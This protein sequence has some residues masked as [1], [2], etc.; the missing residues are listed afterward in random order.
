M[1]PDQESAIESTDH[2]YSN[3][4]NPLNEPHSDD[5]FGRLLDILDA[6][7]VNVERA[8]LHGLLTS[9]A[10]M[11]APD[12]SRIHEAVSPGRAATVELDEAIGRVVSDIGEALWSLAF[13]ARS[14]QG[15]SADG[16]RWLRGYLYALDLHDAQW[17]VL[18]GESE[19]A[20]DAV[21]LCRT[22][23]GEVGGGPALPRHVDARV[24][25]A[26]PRFL[27]DMAAR[28]HG[29]VAG[30]PDW[31]RAE[32]TDA[33]GHRD[34]PA[35]EDAE[36]RAMDVEA[37]VRC[38]L[39]DG[40]RLPRRVVDE[41]IHR[42]DAM[43]TALHVVIDEWDEDDES[44]AW[45]SALHAV[46]IL[47]GVRGAAATEALLAGFLAV[48]ER[49]D[50][51]ADWL[52]TDWPRLF[53]NKE[54]RHIGVMRAIV[55]DRHAGWYA[56]SSAAECVVADA[57]E[58]A[59]ETLEAT[60][61]WILTLTRDTSDDVGFRRLAAMNLLELPRARH[62]RWLEA[63]AAEQVDA[64]SGDRLFVPAD[65]DAAFGEGDRPGWREAPDPLDFY[66]HE[67]IVERQARWAQEAVGGP[68]DDE[69][70]DDRGA[71]PGS[72][73]PYVRA[74]SKVG[75]NDPCPCGSGRKYK[76]CCMP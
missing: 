15:S 59:P 58:R 35:Y 12:L 75:R 14:A 18:L 61:D 24:L 42:G 50:D 52:G 3:P 73:G 34:L 11:P 1:L 36:L 64:P 2:V 65:V 74:Q 16:E 17:S 54:G 67:A 23:L 5:P 20:T 32:P 10:T 31:G 13:E 30:Q 76:R 39:D 45:W 56:R 21:A 37:L 19:V 53:L 70:F 8:W 46:K 60:L 27:A 49:A 71:G 44:D 26:S 51:M 62:R 43:V 47:G 68:F 33:G 28:M 38:V 4:T 55:E 63:M 22:L 25:L 69:S 57:F 72:D 29:A 9:T 48:H 66:E 7:S 6:R 41:C 40:D